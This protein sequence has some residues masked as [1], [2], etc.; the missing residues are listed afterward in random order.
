M[1]II[2]YLPPYMREYREIKEISYAENPEFKIISDEVY[3]MPY[4][5]FAETAGERGVERFENILGITA[6][7]EESLDYRKFRI[8]TRLAGIRQSVEEILN[9]I[10]P[11]GGWSVDYDEQSFKLSVG[12]S[13]INKN[14]LEEV[15]N[16]LDKLL[17]ANIELECGLLYSTHKA[18][19][20][21][22]HSQ[23][24]A[25]THDRLRYPI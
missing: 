16:M 24:K 6:S 15:N 2:K 11:D 1:D 22:K 7:D 14:Y 10:I 5:F 3:N 25:Y 12:L 8:K 13:L 9:S 19:S 23:L 17:P 21:Y 20:Q 4:E 18:L